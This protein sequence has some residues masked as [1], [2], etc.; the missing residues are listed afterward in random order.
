[1]A[2]RPN[3]TGPKEIGPDEIGARKTPVSEVTVVVPCI[4]VCVVPDFPRAAPSFMSGFASSD[5][6]PAGRVRLLV[7]VSRVVSITR[8]SEG[9]RRIFVSTF[10][11]SPASGTER[12]S[13]SHIL[14]T[15]RRMFP[16]FSSRGRID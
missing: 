12:I 13:P 14:R 8:Q 15:A 16:A 10:V 6:P 3:E 4:S 9:R 1:M 5:A 2:R 11:R 7:A